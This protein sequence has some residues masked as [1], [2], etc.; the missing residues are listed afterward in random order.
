M[1]I[2]AVESSCD[3]SALAIF[4][5][6]SGFKAEW[7]A[8]QVALQERYG[9][10]VP[11]LASREHLR[12]LPLL[13]QD[14]L[15]HPAFQDLKAIAVTQGPG[16]SPALAMGISFAQSLALIKGLPL[17]GVNHLRGH[18][19]SPFISTFEE[20]PSTFKARLPELLPHLGLLVSG[21]NTLLFSINE[22]LEL[23]ILS[24]TLDD[25]AGEALDKGARLMG[26]KYPGGPLVE[27]HALSGNP[28]SY[29]FPRALQK[30]LSFSF[31]GLKTALRYLLEKLPPGAIQS[32]LPDLCA[33]Y[34]AA[35]I[36]QLLTK[37]K[38]ALKGSTSFKSLGLSGG[39]A[40]NKALRSHFKHLAQES[41]VPL[42]LSEPKHSGDN[43]SMIAFAFY[44]D[45]SSAKLSP[46]LGL[47]A[48]PW[49]T[50]A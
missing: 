8:T 48:V 13:L 20:D 6:L 40:N 21:G 14:T 39:V 25:A 43:A 2:L 42:L 10:V 19:F 34:Q 28:Q 32:Q 31:S 33:S 41:K 35:V 36:D 18:A 46:N 45:P 4:D 17:Y 30:D 49:L 12:N 50:L 37:T 15:K 23:S 38:A 1:A 9:G 7:I 27:Q 22:A 5:P 3:E 26:L 16:L 44:M 29:T 11:D 24:Q 47:S